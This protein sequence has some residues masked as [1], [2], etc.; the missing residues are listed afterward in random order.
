[1]YDADLHLLRQLFLIFAFAAAVMSQISAPDLILIS[2]H[3]CVSVYKYT[4][5]L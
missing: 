2:D 4:I 1:M 3:V 5:F